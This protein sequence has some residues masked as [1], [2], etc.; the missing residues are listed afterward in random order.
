VAED[1]AADVWMAA[2]RVIPAFDGDAMGFRAWLYGVA[3]RRVADHYRQLGR[4]PRTVALDDID[5]PP[6]PVLPDEMAIAS[7]SAQEAV[8]AL[9]RHLSA[10]Q[11]EV[12]LLRVLGGFSVDEVA[13]L[14]GRSSGSVRALQHR[15]LTHLAT[16]YDALVRD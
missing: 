4:R 1:L 16:V 8:D 5:D 12:V 3:R 13:R 7:I 6:A 15:A 10:A 14:T 2:A 9:T 11:A